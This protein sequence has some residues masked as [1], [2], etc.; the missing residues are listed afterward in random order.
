MP[1]FFN[2]SFFV[3]D[4]ASLLVRDE[5]RYYRTRLLEILSELLVGEIVECQIQLVQCK[6]KRHKNCNVIFVNSYN[7]KFNKLDGQSIRYLKK[8]AVIFI[9]PWFCNIM[10]CSF[11]ITILQPK[12]VEIGIHS[13]PVWLSAKKVPVQR[14]A[15]TVCW[16]KKCANGSFTQRPNKSHFAISW[17]RQLGEKDVITIPLIQIIQ[18]VLKRYATLTLKVGL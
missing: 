5:S 16:R 15:S 13:F 17:P 8:D 6:S 4:F 9:N 12:T 18:F 14:E 2:L 7:V 11:T 10:N 3:N 1:T